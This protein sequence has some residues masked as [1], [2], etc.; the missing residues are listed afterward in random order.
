MDSPFDLLPEWYITL[1]IG[2]V[3]MIIVF[4]I[5][6]YFKGRTLMRHREKEFGIR[7]ISC[8]SCGT[9]MRDVL[10]RCPGCG[11][12]FT[13]NIYRCPSCG[14]TVRGRSVRCHGCGIAL[15]H[16]RIPRTEPKRSNPEKEPTAEGPAVETRCHLIECETCSALYDPC[17]EQCPV[18]RK[19]RYS[20]HR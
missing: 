19:D 16:V 1:S 14:A 4:L 13:G 8:S 9:V 5:W 3:L 18:C 7:S 12:K 10:D 6:A 15:R 11:S 2:L 17:S 20:I